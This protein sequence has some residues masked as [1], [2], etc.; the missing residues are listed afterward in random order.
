VLRARLPLRREVPFYAR[1][2]DL[3]AWLCVALS[4]AF[5]LLALG[6]RRG[7]VSASPASTAACNACETGPT[8]STPTPLGRPHPGS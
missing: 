1:A 8:N 7:Y 3:F 6:E 4:G 2:G 5:A